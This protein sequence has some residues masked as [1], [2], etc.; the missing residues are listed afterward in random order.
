MWGGGGILLFS[1]AIWAGS[2]GERRDTQEHTHTQQERTHECCTYPKVC[3]HFPD[4]EL[5]E[6]ISGKFTGE[7]FRQEKA[8]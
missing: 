4:P 2:G 8:H 6:R 5:T 1:P 7:L 3:A